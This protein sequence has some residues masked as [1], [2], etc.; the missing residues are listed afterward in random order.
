[1]E[2]KT[3]RWIW[4][5]AGAEL[6]AVGCSATV[7]MVTCNVKRVGDGL[8]KMLRMLLEQTFTVIS[9]SDAPAWVNN[10]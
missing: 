7:V 1:M 10:H 2:G 6:A 3:P 4:A 9:V 5:R 8:L